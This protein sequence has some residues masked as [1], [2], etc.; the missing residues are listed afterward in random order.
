[1]PSSVSENIVALKIREGL[2]LWFITVWPNLLSQG[3]CQSLLTDDDSLS[4]GNQKKKKEK[5]RKNE[6]DLSHQSKLLDI[7]CAGINEKLGNYLTQK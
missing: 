3:W 7:L 1:M 2:Q 4:H 5:E 6:S